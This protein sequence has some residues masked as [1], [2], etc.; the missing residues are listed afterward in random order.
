MKMTRDSSLTLSHA[1]SPMA[2]LGPPF[3][4]LVRVQSIDA[5]VSNAE[6]VLNSR[7]ARE[8]DIRG[9][10]TMVTVRPDRCPPKGPNMKSRFETLK[11]NIVLSYHEVNMCCNNFEVYNVH[12]Q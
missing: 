10:A 6:L 9:G 11:V 8:G 4:F 1:R 3:K 7:D 5:F 12:R 2:V